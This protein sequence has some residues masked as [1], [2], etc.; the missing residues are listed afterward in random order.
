MVT[1]ALMDLG[2]R[3]HTVTTT[4]EGSPK[5]YKAKAPPAIAL[6]AIA[7]GRFPTHDTPQGLYSPQQSLTTRTTGD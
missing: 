5:T 1:K 4:T 7:G 2:G 6:R 3:V